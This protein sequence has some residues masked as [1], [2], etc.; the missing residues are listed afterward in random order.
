ML[1]ELITSVPVMSEDAAPGAAAAAAGGAGG[2]GAAAG[3]V[4]TGAAAGASAVASPEAKVADTVEDEG[5]FRSFEQ[6]AEDDAV[7]RADARADELDPTTEAAALKRLFANDTV[8]AVCEAKLG[9]R[10]KAI[11]SVWDSWGDGC[12]DSKLGAAI[13]KVVTTLDAPH[14]KPSGIYERLTS[15]TDAACYGLATLMGDIGAPE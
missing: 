3:A 10:F 4:G 2:S 13:A 8:C 6:V 15:G 5:G 7:Y 14:L 11:S 12:D 1:G 9:D